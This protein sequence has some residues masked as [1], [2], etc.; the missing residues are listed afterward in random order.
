MMD[1]FL[2]KLLSLERRFETNFFPKTLS[3]L[4]KGLFKNGTP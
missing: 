3:F 1:A 2:V 4:K